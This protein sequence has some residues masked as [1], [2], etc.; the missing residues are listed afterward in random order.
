MQSRTGCRSGAA[1]LAPPRRS[2]PDAGRSR[3]D[4]AGTK[5]ILLGRA[6][7]SDID[8]GLP[9]WMVPP[10]RGERRSGCDRTSTISPGLGLA[11][12]RR[13][14]AAARWLL[15]SRAAAAAST[16]GQARTCA[17]YPGGAAAGRP[18]GPPTPEPQAGSAARPRACRPGSAGQRR[19]WRGRRHARG[20]ARDAARRGARRSRRSVAARRI[21]ARDGLALR[22]SHVRARSL[23]LPRPAKQGDAC[24]RS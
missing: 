23:F 18:A 13:L 5:R 22:D 12:R 21:G 16:P 7:G 9:A 6:V 2:R 1:S 4:G 8:R 17:A 11:G 24:P 19:P 14:L 15:L 20:I 10:K 3:L